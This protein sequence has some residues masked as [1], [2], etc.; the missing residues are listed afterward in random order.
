M[1]G[2]NV[3]NSCHFIRKVSCLVMGDSS[4]CVQIEKE[5][6][7]SISINSRL[8]HMMLFICKSHTACSPEQFRNASR[9][10]KTKQYL[11]TDVQPLRIGAWLC[12]RCFLHCPRLC[13]LC[14]AP[15]PGFHAIVV[16]LFLLWPLH[17][18]TFL[19]FC[20]GTLLGWVFSFKNPF[21]P[22]SSTI[23][24]MTKF[25]CLAMTSPGIL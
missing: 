6:N 18:D 1:L 9:S 3:M 12:A 13:V 11:F 2:R 10:L 8:Y 24:E 7:R 25:V 5:G 16:L 4:N 21:I 15:P 14:P 17:V 19:T 23:R 20:P 22:I